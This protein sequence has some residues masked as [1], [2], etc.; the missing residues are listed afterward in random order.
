MT[1]ATPS[2]GNGVARP[3]TGKPRPRRNYTDAFMNAAV[4]RMKKGELIDAVAKDLDVSGT[5]LRRWAD[6]AAAGLKPSQRARQ[7]AYAVAAAAPGAKKRVVRDSEAFAVRDAIVYLKHVKTDI[8]AK[9][10]VSGKAGRAAAAALFVQL[11]QPPRF[12]AR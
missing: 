10:H 8:Y 4:K 2:S 5:V 11:H 12:S 6:K 1:D 3:K 9:L 7:K